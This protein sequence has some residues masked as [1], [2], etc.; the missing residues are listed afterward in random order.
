MNTFLR[1]IFFPG[2][3]FKI[4]SCFCS[5]MVVWCLGCWGWGPILGFWGWGFQLMG[6]GACGVGPSGFLG[7][8]TYDFILRYLKVGGESVDLLL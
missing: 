6:F 2:L 1:Y 7:L 8:E 5:F 4:F 3:L